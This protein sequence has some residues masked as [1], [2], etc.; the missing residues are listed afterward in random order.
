MANLIAGLN[1]QYIK[2][3][4]MRDP[5]V[6]GFLDDVEGTITISQIP[7]GPEDEER[8]IADATDIPIVYD[9]GSTNGTYRATIPASANLIAGTRYRVRFTSSNYDR[10]TYRDFDCVVG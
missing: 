3:S 9:S 2:L 5:A 4:R 10:D 8:P 6:A 7:S 1:S